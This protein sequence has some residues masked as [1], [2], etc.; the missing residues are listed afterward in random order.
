[1]ISDRDHMLNCLARWVLSNFKTA[2]GRRESLA[3]MEKKHGAAFIAD[4]KAR[5]TREWEKK[6][7]TK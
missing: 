2:P 4:L 7:A 6:N 5:I 1:M 3:R